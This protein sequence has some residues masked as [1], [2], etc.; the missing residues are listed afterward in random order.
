MAKGLGKGMAALLPT[1][2]DTSIL[3]DKSE[4]VQKVFISDVAANA[5]QPR[6]SFDEYALKEIASSMERVGI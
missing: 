1:E 4:R 3:L 5:D 2:F 6:R